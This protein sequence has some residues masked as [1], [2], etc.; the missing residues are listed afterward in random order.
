MKQL[1]ANGLEQV[2]KEL[3]TTGSSDKIFGDFSPSYFFRNTHW[4]V[5]DG[6]EGCLEPRVIVTQHIRHFSRDAKVILTFRHPTPRLY[7]RFLS[8][9]PRTS[10]L[11]DNRPDDFHRYVLQGVEAFSQCFAKWSVRHCVYNTSLHQSVTLRL[12]EG[13]YPTFMADWLRVW[14]RNQLHIMRY[15]DYAGHEGKRIMEIFEFLGLRPLNATEMVKIS[16]KD[17]S[18]SGAREYKSVGAML[19]E[20]K[21]ILDKFYQPFINQ[22]AEILNEKRFLWLDTKH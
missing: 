9:I 17:V 6:N 18:N 15:E 13:M 14:P 5:L 11:K 2:E 22:F 12:M 19:P 1:T 4:P 10:I 7:S 20:T 21:A 8:R 3:Q 16:E